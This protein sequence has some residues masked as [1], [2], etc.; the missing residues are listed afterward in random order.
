MSTLDLTKRSGGTRRTGQTSKWPRE[1]DAALL[2]GT[3]RQWPVQIRVVTGCGRPEQQQDT[4]YLCK[5]VAELERALA[6]M[7]AE[8]LTALQP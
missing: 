4:A 8:Y 1:A 2:Q 6:T 7:R 5:N 3:P